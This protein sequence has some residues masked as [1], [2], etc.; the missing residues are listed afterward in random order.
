[1]G[2]VTGASSARNGT[3]AS[4]LRKAAPTV[5]AAR[6]VRV[7][8]SRLTRHT[9]RSPNDQMT[10]IVIRE[11]DHCRERTLTAVG[12]VRRRRTIEKFEGFHRCR[13]RNLSTYF[14]TIA[15]AA[16]I[17]KG[18]LASDRTRMPTLMPEM[19]ALARF[20]HRPRRTRLS[21]TSVRT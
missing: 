11:F 9:T 4:Q 1:M 10:A 21:T 14:D 3:P 20:G 5:N 8:W 19:Y 7:T 2:P 15:S 16:A 6:Y 17:T 18:Q 12:A 13:P